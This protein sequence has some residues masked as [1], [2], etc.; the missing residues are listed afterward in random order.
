MLQ[1]MAQQR[2]AI[3]AGALLFLLPLWEKVALTKSASDEGFL[4]DGT[5]GYPSPDRATR[6][7]PLPQ[8]ERE[9]RALGTD[10][11][12]KKKGAPPAQDAL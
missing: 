8:G 6:G 1:Q 5:L 9:E 11:L 3:V 10:A 7:H 4:G 12:D 2:P